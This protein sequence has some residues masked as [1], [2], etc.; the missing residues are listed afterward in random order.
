MKWRLPIRR[1]TS[2]TAA[3]VVTFEDAILPHLDSAY[4]IARWLVG[5]PTLPEDVVQDAT[6]RA[7]RYF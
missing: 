7:L 3:A 4:N 1:D 5:D 6:V 2:A